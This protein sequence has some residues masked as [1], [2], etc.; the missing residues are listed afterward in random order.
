MACRQDRHGLHHLAFY[1]AVAGGVASCGDSSRWTE[2]A[3]ALSIIY[4]ALENFVT[5]KID[6]RWRDTFFFGFVHGF[7]FA[8]GLIEMGVPQRAIVPALASFNIG[9]EVGQI[10]VVLIVVPLLVLI[11]KRFFHGKRDLRLVQVCSAAVACAGV[12]WLF[13]PM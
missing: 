13:F 7:G 5:R 12:Y 3:I 9:V 8:S 2:I 10:G 1:H 6:G 4:V 11:D